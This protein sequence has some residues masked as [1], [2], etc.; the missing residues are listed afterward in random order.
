MSAIFPLGVHQR[1]GVF[2]H[3]PDCLVGVK[4]K[5]HLNSYD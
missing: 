1:L 5:I 4:M 2:Y 3:C